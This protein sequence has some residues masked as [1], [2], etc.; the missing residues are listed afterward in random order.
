MIVLLTQGPFAIQMNTDYPHYSGFR[1]EG[2]SQRPTHPQGP[3]QPQPQ[4]PQ[5]QNFLAD[6]SHARFTMQLG[7]HA[8][9]AGQDFL[10]KH[11]FIYLSP[12]RLT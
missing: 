1:N 10:S 3:P 12:I 7:A 9:S 2:M 4:I 11:V 8:I 5:P 6:N